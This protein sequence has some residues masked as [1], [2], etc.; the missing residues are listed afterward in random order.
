[1]VCGLIYLICRAVQVLA[2][3]LDSYANIQEA[4][5]LHIA[6]MIEDGENVDDIIELK[7]DISYKFDLSTFFEEFPITIT[8]V[9]KK[10][11]INRSL[12]SQYIDGSK[13]LSIN[14]AE[15]IQKAI[16][17][18]GNEISKVNFI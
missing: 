18:I 15:K 17:D 2:K 11:G 16:Q 13:K 7:K 6:G 10:S 3:I 12:I 5:D 9:A 14:Q 4:I 8:G 1:M